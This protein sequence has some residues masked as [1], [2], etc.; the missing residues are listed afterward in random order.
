M[1]NF[2]VFALK[3]GD[4]VNIAGA[5]L[6]LK[7]CTTDLKRRENELQ[8]A[9]FRGKT[10]YFNRFCK[11]VD[12]DPWGSAYQA[13]IASIKGKHSPSVTNPDFLRDYYRLPTSFK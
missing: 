10:E 7:S 12:C 3:P 2:A 4:T 5:E 9:T 6:S 1:K 13:M 8:V 11:K